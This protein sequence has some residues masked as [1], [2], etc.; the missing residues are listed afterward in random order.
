M[1]ASSYRR[2]L[3]AGA[4]VCIGVFVTWLALPLMG[5]GV[6]EF[7]R[8]GVFGTPLAITIIPWENVAGPNAIFLGLM[9]LA[10]WA[11]LRPL[12]QSAVLGNGVGHPR[13]HA[14]LAVAFAAA[15][16]CAAVLATVLEMPDQWKPGFQAMMGWPM[17]TTFVLVWAAWCIVFYIYFRAGDFLAKAETVV[18]VLIRGSCLELL[19]AIPTHALVYRRSTQ[20]CYCERGSYTGIVF[21]FAVLLWAF[22]PGLML[23]YL[24]E[25]QRRTPV[26][27]R[28]CPRC[29]ATLDFA[30][31]A[32]PRCQRS[33]SPV[34]QN[35]TL[36]PQG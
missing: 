36:R 9:L 17:W 21:G 18:R 8:Y 6:P 33:A 3:L 1:S 27:Q 29:G 28:L 16:L 13:W 2:L 7:A 32:C 14:I 26:L 12:R 30:S 10:Q 20:D 35:T 31:G 34:S 22:G 5:G 24:R 11:F 4:I 25:N 15:M 23:L 19:V